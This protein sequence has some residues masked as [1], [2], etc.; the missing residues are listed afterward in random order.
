MIFN[1]PVGRCHSES[2]TR[3]LCGEK[4]FKNTFSR[5]FIHALVAGH[6][7]WGGSYPIGGSGRIAETILPVIESRNGAVYTSAEVETILVEEFQPEGPFGAKGMGEAVLV[8]TRITYPM[9]A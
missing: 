5:F 1:D 4:G 7:L 2:P 6:Y 3:K 8:P 9:M